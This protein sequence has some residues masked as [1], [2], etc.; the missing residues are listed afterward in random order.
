MT[1]IAV[2]TSPKERALYNSLAGFCWGVG[3]ILGPVIGGAFADSKATWRWAFYINLVLAAISAPIYIFC[4]PRFDPQPNLSAREKWTQVDWIGV[5]LKATFISLLMIVLSF[6]GSSWGWSSGG[7]IALWVLFCLSLIAFGFQQTFAISTTK[8]HRLFPVQ[9]LK[10]R[11]LILVYFGTAAAGTSLFM[12][13]Y[14]VPLFFQFTKN[15]SASQAAVRLLP[16]VVVTIFFIMIAGALLPMFGWYHAWYLVSGILILIGGILMFKV[17]P[18]THTAAIYGFEIIIAV[19]TGLTAMIGYS[20]A[21]TKVEPREVQH[22]IGY[23]NVAQIG[24]V[25]LA[26]SISGSI[27]QNLGYKR[28]QAV[29]DPY[30]FTESEVR[31]ALAGTQSAVFSNSSSQVK[32]LAIEAITSTISSIYSLLMAA[33]ALMIVS[34]IL[35]KKEKLQ[36]THSVAGG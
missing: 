30:G 4:F 32:E 33:G 15:D 11:T 18:V 7:T 17:T 13:I 9:F 28:L 14:Y 26:L 23:I 22:A 20:I 5:L 12:T 8:E 27:F 21:A 34:A 36:L 35:M 24:G 25:A 1:Y 6:A 2:F 31:L 19:G 29:L 10:S 3:C 16:F